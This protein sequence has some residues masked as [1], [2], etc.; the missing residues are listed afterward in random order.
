MY[1][2]TI[3]RL[4]N[5]FEVVFAS[6]WMA[7]ELTFS[8]FQAGLASFRNKAD[9]LANDPE[10]DE[11]ASHRTCDVKQSRLIVR[12]RRGNIRE[13]AG[14]RGAGYECESRHHGEEARLC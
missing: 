4:S 7:S 1:A 6:N 11:H 13:Q 9:E 12:E 3:A 2:I 5:V 8:I 10:S 14:R